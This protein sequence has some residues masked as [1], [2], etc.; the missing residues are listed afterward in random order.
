MSGN[1]LKNFTFGFEIEGFFERDFLENLVENEAKKNRVKV[2]YKKDYS[3]HWEDEEEL[4]ENYSDYTE[5][6]IGIFMS[7]QSMI[8]FLSL[9]NRENGYIYNRTCGLHIHLKPKRDTDL[10][11]RIGDWQ[12][13]RDLQEFAKDN[14][15]E[16]IYPRV[17]DGGG[18]WCRTYGGIETAWRRWRQQEKYSFLR[19][20]PIGTVEFRFF[21]PCE[22]KI[23][24]AINFFDFLENKLKE[25]KRRKNKLI[26]LPSE[27]E[28]LFINF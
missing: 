22:H 24:N 6:A 12:L 8:D 21:S 5:L 2:N 1:V 20:H 23:E 11:R 25:T 17:I 3:V 28:K 14:L 10:R 13:I 18:R 15:C 9:F 26:F 19:N 7:F 16:H 27:K 4:E